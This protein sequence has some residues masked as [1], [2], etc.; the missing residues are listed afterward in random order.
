M[1]PAT[2]D[3]LERKSRRRG[4]FGLFL[5]GALTSLAD[6]LPRRHVV[7]GHDLLLAAVR[8]FD[9]TLPNHARGGCGR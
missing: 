7:H 8:L 5:R 1:V 9:D 3:G 6:E 2:G 4:G